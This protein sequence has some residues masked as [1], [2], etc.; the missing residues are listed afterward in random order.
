MRARLTPPR[1]LDHGSSVWWAWYSRVHC[2]QRPQPVF[3]PIHL[4]PVGCCVSSLPAMSTDLTDGGISSQSSQRK[5]NRRRAPEGCGSSTTR[6][7]NS[8]ETIV[9]LPPLKRAAARIASTS[10]S[11]SA[12]ATLGSTATLL[13]VERQDVAVLQARLLDRLL[14]GELD[15]VLLEDPRAV[16]LELELVDGLLD[17]DLELLVLRE[18]V[19]VVAAQRR[20]RERDLLVVLVALLGRLLLCRHRNLLRPVSVVDWNQRFSRSVFVL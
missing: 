1:R 3:R 10:S 5:R 7:G 13:R 20:D 19:G 6:S 2:A 18:V 14:G 15:A 4:P 11:K 12:L 8:A 16:A 9:Q 17:H